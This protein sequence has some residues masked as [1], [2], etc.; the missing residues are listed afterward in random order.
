MNKLR[1]KIKKVIIDEELITKGERVALGLSGGPDSICLLEILFSLKEEIGFTLEALHVNHMIRGV[2]ADEDELFLKEY[3]QEKGVPLTSVKLDVSALSKEN[4]KTE[5]EM[6]R[7]LRI[8]ELKKLGAD[9]IAL[10]HNKNDQAETI[11]MRII[12]GTGV[13]GLCGM[14][15]KRE[16]GVIRPLLRTPRAEIEEFVA[17][18]NLPARQDKTNFEAEY[19]RNKIRL[20]L[21]P[22][23]LEF[24]PNIVDALDRLSASASD[25][26]EL[27]SAIADEFLQSN[28]DKVLKIK[29]LSQLS[30]AVFARVITRYL[31]S[32]GLTE[33]ISAV[34]IKALRAAVK[35]NVGNKTIEFPHGFNILLKNGNIKV[36]KRDA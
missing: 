12:R 29:D 10:A 32:F 14:E 7:D 34:H 20:E 31:A 21:L 18:N 19:T 26:E 35:K 5:E 27:L 8:L 9:K 16:D 23:L 28:R 25:D 6:G 17:E 24:N 22:K 33:D 30:D 2:E 36:L 13:S 11:L 15:I 4:D 1:D 3:C